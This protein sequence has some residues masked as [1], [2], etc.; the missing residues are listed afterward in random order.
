V[1]YLCVRRVAP[2]VPA[3]AP[4]KALRSDVS[5]PTRRCSSRAPWAVGSAATTGEPPRS[6]AV[7]MK[8]RQEGTAAAAVTDHGNRRDSCSTGAGPCRWRSGGHGGDS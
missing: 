1:F 6:E 4:T 2:T 5:V 7:A 3:L 8:P